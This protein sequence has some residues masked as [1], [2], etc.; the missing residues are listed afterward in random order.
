MKIAFLQET[1]N[2]NIGVMYL[3]AV[4]KF[5]GYDCQLFAEPLENDFI[6]AV[7]SYQPDIIGFS[8]ITGAHHWAL[9]VSRQLKQ[10]LPNSLVLFGG[11]HPTYFSE[12]VESP[13]VDAV[14]RGEAEISLPEFIGRVEKGQKYTDVQGF[15]V[16]QRG[17]IFRNDVAF[18]VDDISTLPYPDHKLYLKYEFYRNQTEVPFST[19]RGCPFRCSFCYN[20]VKASLYKGKGKYLRTRNIDGVIGEMGLARKLYPNMTSVILYDDIIGLDK[21]WLADFSDAYAEHVG[22]PWFTSIRADLVD[23][24]VVNKLAKAKC[25]CLSLG[26]ETGD[27]ELRER[28]LGK[29]IPNSQYLKAARLLHDAGI[30][31][32]TSNMVF[33]PGEDIKKAKSTVDINRAMKVDFAWA[34]TLQPYPGTDIY[35]YAVKNGYLSSAF[36]FDDIDPLGLLKPI[37][38]TKDKDKILVLH[39]FFNFAV[40]HTFMRK[41]L[42]I[43]IYLPPN[44]LFDAVYSLSLILSYADYHQVSFLRALRVAW[45]NYWSTKRKKIKA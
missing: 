37:I 34:Y 3:S 39:R 9:D 18:L 25:F 40:H 41:L 4:L 12:I 26:V 30:K 7:A 44:P 24:F 45:N 35:D 27:E 13:Y 20:H 28:V 38:D 6:R 19:T 31:V 17:S 5:N 15:W 23:E 22:L 8:L 2:Q 16:K 21:K 10:L 33:L 29:R 14:S 43:L 32:R 42:N 36:Q 1:V 11:P